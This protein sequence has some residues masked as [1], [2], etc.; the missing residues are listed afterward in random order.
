MRRQT[1][2]T[3]VVALFVGLVA[4]AAEA[5][6]VPR[7]TLR[8]NPAVGLKCTSRLAGVL[9]DAAVQGQSLGVSGDVAANMVTEVTARDGE[10]STTIVRL[11]LSDVKASL[12]GRTTTPTAPSPLSVAIGRTGRMAE[13]KDQNAAEVTFTETGGIPITMV[14]MLASA[15]RFPDEAV[16]VGDEWRSEDTCYVPGIGESP[17]NSRWRLVEFNGTVATITSSASAAL[18]DF[19][20]RDPFA[21]GTQMDVRAGRAYITGLKQVFDTATSRLL[22]AGGK[23]RIDAQLDM[24]GMTVPVTLTMS[25]TLKPQEQPEASAGQAAP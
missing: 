17:M 11:A 2:T 10:A 6:Q 1:A 15:V 24:Q 22:A 19:R 25:F 18:P 13:A 23:L 7:Y 3:A 8:Y 5:E 14:A 12:N 21:S 4:C 20:T 9:L 16:A